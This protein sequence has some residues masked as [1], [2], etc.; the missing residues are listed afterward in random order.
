MIRKTMVF[1]ALVVLLA[2]TQA[3]AQIVDDA[4]WQQQRWFERRRGV[5]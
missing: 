5:L 3:N 1:G 2:A 4:V